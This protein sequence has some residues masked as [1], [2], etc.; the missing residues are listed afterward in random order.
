MWEESRKRTLGSRDKQILWERAGRKCEACGEPIS[1]IE[2]QVG[3]KTAF[4]KGGSTT[5][6][7]SV[8]LCYK[9]NKL[10][11]TDSWSKFL[12]KLGKT[13]TSS[14]SKDLLKTLT[15]TQLK[16]LTKMHS[17]KV[18]GKKVE[19]FFEDTVKPP[20]KSQYISAIS[21]KISLQEINE[22][23]NK[24]PQPEKKQKKRRKKKD[25]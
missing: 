8:C 10:Q 5:L 4:S 21:K 19:G 7:N 16:E 6:R 3:H 11:G 12:K 2:M 13:P 1:Y 17:I 20:T 9:C 25:P 22:S 14:D 15:V 18:R 24:I 23:I